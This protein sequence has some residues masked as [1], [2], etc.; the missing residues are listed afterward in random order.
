MG[1]VASLASAPVT[2]EVVKDEARRAK[3]HRDD[4]KYGRYEHG[5][6]DLVMIKRL[7]DKSGGGNNAAA[8]EAKDDIN[9]NQGMMAGNSMRFPNE[10]FN[11]RRPILSN[12]VT[13]STALY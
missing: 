4:L 6:S 10:L 7:A 3:D 13:I 11:R 2:A 5:N 9:N 1:M 8:A 12:M